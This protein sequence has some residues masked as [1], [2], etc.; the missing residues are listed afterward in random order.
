MAERSIGLQTVPEQHEVNEKAWMIRPIRPERMIIIHQRFFTDISSSITSSDRIIN[1]H[2]F[3]SIY[4]PSLPQPST[5]QHLITRRIQRQPHQAS[6]NQAR[7]RDSH[8]PRE[9]QQTD[10]LPID[11]LKSAIAETHTDRGARDTHARRHGKRVLREDED[12][13]GGAHFHGR[14]ARGGVVG[15]FVAHDCVQK[16]GLV[17]C[18]LT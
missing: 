8:D 9:E 12:G 5:Q 7:N 1:Q 3:P 2:L 10:T 4:S 6:T 17:G 13:D 16:D 14:T 18:A 15:D 11:S